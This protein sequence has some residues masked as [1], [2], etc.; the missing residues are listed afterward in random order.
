MK[1][2]SFER[3]K[4]I[5]KN[6]N[7]SL[8]RVENWV[9]RGLNGVGKTTLLSLGNNRKHRS[10]RRNFWEDKCFS[11]EKRIGLI[12]TTIQSQFPEHHLA[13]YIALSGK[14]GTI[15]IHND[16][17]KNDLNEAIGLLKKLGGDELINKPYR[18]LSQG[19]RRLALISRAL[20][21]MNCLYLTNHVMV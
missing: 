17:E 13:Q 12:S 9:L 11:V 4:I 7:W 8:H 2:V 14:F 19:Q 5:L 18:V 20:L 3:D 6:I 15:G 10:S 1:N 16:F 21:N